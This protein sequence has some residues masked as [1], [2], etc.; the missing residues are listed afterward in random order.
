MSAA[1]VSAGRVPHSMFESELT[2]L[3]LLQAVLGF[4]VLQWSHVA[5]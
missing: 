3:T 1:L 5:H 2:F 4:G